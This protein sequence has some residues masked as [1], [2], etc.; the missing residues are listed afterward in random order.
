MEP[1]RIAIPRINDEPVD[2]RVMGRIWS[3]VNAAPP[4]SDIVFDLSTCDFLRPNAVVFLG[5]LTHLVARGGGKATFNMDQMPARSRTALV[6]CG[7]AKAMGFPAQPW[8]GNSI[9]Y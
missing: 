2:F 1:I 8:H 3:T 7:F 4:N 6:Q 9:P 5:G